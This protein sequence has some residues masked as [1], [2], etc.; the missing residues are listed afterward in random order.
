MFPYYVTCICTNL[1]PL[2]DGHSDLNRTCPHLTV[3]LGSCVTPQVMTALVP[4]MTLWSCGGVV[5]RVR[6]AETKRE[7][8]SY[9][10]DNRQGNDLP[11][12]EGRRK[13]KTNKFQKNSF[14]LK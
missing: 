7:R 6:A 13:N 11:E 1:L 14:Q 12:E 9:G 2:S 5:I 8:D 10:G 3:T 4:L